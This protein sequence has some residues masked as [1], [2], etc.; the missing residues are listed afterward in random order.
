MLAGFT[1]RPFASS[2]EFAAQKAVFPVMSDFYHTWQ[3]CFA[4]RA[5]HREL[6]FHAIT[7][8]NMCPGPCLAEQILVE[9][10]T[11]VGMRK[12]DEFV[13]IRHLID[14]VLW[15]DRSDRL[16]IEHICSMELTPADADLVLGNN[17]DFSY[18][19]GQVLKLVLALE[20][21]QV[22]T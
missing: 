2:S 14:R 4:D 20:A 21:A 9:H 3:D 6:W 11:Y 17:R 5:N 16:P 19:A 1:E 8:Y 7:A 10:G 12:R 22:K 13:K 18:L 15:V